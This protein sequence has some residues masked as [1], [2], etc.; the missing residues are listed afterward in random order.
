[1]N[2]ISISKKKLIEIRDLMLYFELPLYKNDS[3]RSAFVSL[4][5]SPGQLFKKKENQLILFE[6]FNLDI[7]E[8]DRLAIVGINGIGKS[9]LCRCIAGIYQA[10]K[11]S[12]KTIGNVRAIFD[13]SVSIQPE[14]TGRENAQLLTEFFYPQLSKI[15]KARL[16]DESL[17][18][19]ELQ[20]FLDAP[21][22]FYSAGMN[23]RLCLSL[24]SARPGDV[25]IL[26]E[27][28]DGADQ[29]FREKVS[30]RILE[31]IRNSGAVVFI[32]HSFDQIRK[33]CNRVIVL[34]QGKIVFDGAASEAEKIYARM[35][36]QSFSS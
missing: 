15:E 16:I 11:G 26:D 14:L 10:Q 34:H 7:F 9:S 6:Q 35:A 12:I 25:L 18:F 33:V 24:I 22:K 13:A 23:V 5:E 28:F 4:F 30:K 27:V 19:S 20:M 1:M 32:S 31:M 29:F 2:S 17:N 3:L 8:G 21:V 36:K